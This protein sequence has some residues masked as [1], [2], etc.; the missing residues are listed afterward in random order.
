MYYLHCYVPDEGKNFNITHKQVVNEIFQK[1]PIR[2]N[3]IVGPVG[4]VKR[5]NE[6]KVLARGFDPNSFIIDFT[7]LFDLRTMHFI[8]FN[9]SN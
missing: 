7:V 8:D 6:V 1:L 5:K 9:I 4:L 3:N 2:K